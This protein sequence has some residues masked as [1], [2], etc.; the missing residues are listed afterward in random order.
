MGGVLRER[1]GNR[2]VIIPEGAHHLD[3]RYPHAKDPLS[4]I[5]A[6]DVER[7]FI[8]ATIAARRS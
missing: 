7:E 8:R 1:N 4:V 2:A 3:L 6:R 5:R